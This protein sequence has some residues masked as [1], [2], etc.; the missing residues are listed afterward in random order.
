MKKTI[1]MK[2]VVAIGILTL[3]FVLFLLYNNKPGQD[4]LLD[5]LCKGDAECFGG[6]VEDIIDGD[7]LEVDD[8]TIRLVLINTPE[9]WEDDYEAAIDFLWGVCPIGS[10]VIVDEDDM[11]TSRSHGRMIA[12][13]YC[14]YRGR[15]INLN[16]ELLEAGHADIVTDFCEQSEF[17]DEEWA[18]LH[19]CG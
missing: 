10:A 3:L 16:E 19:G 12:A 2:S 11:Q 9:K 5:T 7:T 13:V 18:R 17:A 8:E 14:E 6:T 4:V 1:F 15:Y